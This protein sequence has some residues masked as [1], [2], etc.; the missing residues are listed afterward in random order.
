MANAQ[1]MLYGSRKPR[2]GGGPLRWDELL[3]SLS[4]EDRY[5]MAGGQVY[6]KPGHCLWRIN[7]N[8]HREDGP[9]LEIQDLM[10]GWFR[11]GQAHR[12]DG[13]AVEYA[14][15]GCEWWLDGEQITEAEWRERT[16]KPRLTRRSRSDIVLVTKSL[17]RDGSG[18]RCE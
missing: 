17:V 3:A 2:S 15:G 10:R 4:P 18:R 6:G 8:L 13:P 5:R 14:N 12:E 7:G 16:G 9:A 1:K 11:H